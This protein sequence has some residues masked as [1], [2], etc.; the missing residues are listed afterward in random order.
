MFGQFLFGKSRGGGGDWMADEIENMFE[1]V[2]YF[3]IMDGYGDDNAIW[4]FE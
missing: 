3:V 1:K 2:V 4:K